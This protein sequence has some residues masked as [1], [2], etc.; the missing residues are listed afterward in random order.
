MLPVIYYKGAMTRLCCLL[1]CCQWEQVKCLT[2]S[3][4]GMQ[5]IDRQVSENGVV[6]G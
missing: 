3:C 6:L 4:S 5:N 2:A 1:F